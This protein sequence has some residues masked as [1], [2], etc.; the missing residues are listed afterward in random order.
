[1]VFAFIA[2]QPF[3]FHSD[4]D[5]CAS[6]VPY[7]SPDATCSNTK[8]SYQCRCNQGFSGDGKECKGKILRGKCECSKTGQLKKNN[9]FMSSSR[10]NNS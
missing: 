1:M 4:I 6:T 8:G 3:F 2:M 10:S 5:E 7:C 9:G